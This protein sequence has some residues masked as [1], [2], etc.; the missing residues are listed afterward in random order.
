MTRL[1]LILLFL[2]TTYLAIAQQRVIFSNFSQLQSYYNP[3]LTG[4]GG[5]KLQT[6]YRNQWTGFEDAPKTALAIADLTPN[7]FKQ[8]VGNERKRL[9]EATSSKHNFGIQV[10]HDSFGPYKESMLG[11]SYGAAISLSENMHLRWGGTLSYQLNSLDGNSLTVDQ[12]NDPMYNDALGQN[13]RLSKA[14]L[15]IGI[16]LTS[17]KLMA[18]YTLKDITEGKV[19]ASGDDFLSDMFARSHVLQAGFRSILTGKTG[20]VLNTLYQYDKRRKGLL[21]GHAKLVYDNLLWV[22]GGYRQDLSYQVM[23]G[24]NLKK[25]TVAYVYETP[26]Q[27]SKAI[28]KPSNE[29]TLGFRLT[30]IINSSDK[31]TIW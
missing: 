23:A 13:N 16:A 20:V 22:G 15:S 19:A 2:S 1:I 31:V 3:A 30:P 9:A 29:I 17:Q 7:L 24:L 14:D 8:R 10:L 25:F 27:E 18:G 26:E 4:N 11:L 5:A 28:Q 12:E 6:A 21:E